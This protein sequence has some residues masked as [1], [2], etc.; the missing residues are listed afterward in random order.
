M[1]TVVVDVTMTVI[2]MN[3]VADVIMIAIMIIAEIGK[4][5]WKSALKKST[6]FLFKNFLI[7]FVKGC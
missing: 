7:L 1:M 5:L 4:F 3:A 2:V 6:L